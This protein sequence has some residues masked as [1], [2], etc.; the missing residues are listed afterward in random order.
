MMLMCLVVTGCFLWPQGSWLRTVWSLL[1]QWLYVDAP[2]HWA[3]AGFGLPCM[4][5]SY[6]VPFND[7]QPLNSRYGNEV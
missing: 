6:L 4:D 5:G 3:W 1:Y 7:T 2:M